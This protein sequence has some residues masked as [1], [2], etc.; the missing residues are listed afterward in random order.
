MGPAAVG[1]SGIN[2][3]NYRSRSRSR[4][5]ARSDARSNACTRSGAMPDHE[6]VG[7]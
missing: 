4:E 5:T 6:K 7:A 3:D 2:K 1:P